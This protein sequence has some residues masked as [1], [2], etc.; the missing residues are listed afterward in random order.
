MTF[1]FWKRVACV[2]MLGWPVIAMTEA[3]STPD[4]I[5]MRYQRAAEVQRS[6]SEHWVLN[7]SVTPHWI[8][9]KNQF[10]YERQIPEGRRFTVFDV[11]RGTKSDAFDH[12]RIAYDL[13]KQLDKPI[14]PN[15]LP[16]AGL[17]LDADGALSFSAVGKSWRFDK[18]KGLTEDNDPESKYTASPDGKRGVFFKDHNLWIKD[19]K[20]GAEAR[21]TADGEEFYAY[22]VGPA[23]LS[24][25][26]P[27][28]APEV[29]WSP[30]SKYIFTAQTDDRKVLNAPLIDFA[31]KGSLPEDPLPSKG[32][33]LENRYR[34]KLINDRVAFPGDEN[35]PTFRLTI[36]DAGDGRQ[37]AVRYPPIPAVR[38]NDSPMSGNRMWWSTD[39]KT[40]Y[41]VDIE[42]G[43]KTV[44]VEAV[45][46]NT[47]AARELFSEANETF[48]ELGSDVYAPATIYPLPKSHQLIWYSER[49]GWAHL[50]LY[51]QETGRLVRALTSGN[52]V[53]HDILGVD[54]NLGQ[55]LISIEGRTKNKNPY[56]REIARVNIKTG[57][58]K[59]VS[60][61][62][63]DHQVL[64]TASL[65][66]LVAVMTGGDPRGLQ[67][68]APSG[69]YFVETVTTADK[70]SQ[71]VVRDFD[72]NRVAT[73]E[74]A[75]ASRL[76]S[77]WRW[78]QPVQLSGA[79]GRTVINA[80]VFKPFDYDPHRK[81]PL[82]DCVY[83]GPQMAYVPRGYGEPQYTEAATY[84]G[85]GFFAV[86]IDGRGTTERSRDFHTQSYRKAETTSN[87]EDHIAVIRE[88]ASADPGID[89]ARV[90]ITGF[91]GGGY[92]TASAMLRYPEFYKVGAAGSGNHDQ[93]VFWNT[94][95]E[96]Y[97]GY[98]MGDYYQEQASTT[99][100]GNLKGKLLL[101]HGLLDTGVHPS[102]LFQLE[103]AL[104]DANKDFDLLVWPRARHELPSYGIRRLWDYFIEN[105]AGESP[106]HEYYLKTDADMD[107]EKNEALSAEHR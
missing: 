11:D 53:V 42:R 49:S 74:D 79:D 65:S 4:Q 50:Y 1:P 77:W 9:G 73:V 14:D 20:S 19:F 88:L 12:M 98:P 59:I 106:P 44:H 85:L 32:T 105:L 81:Y 62:D 51:D 72:G 94:W 34:P 31:P 10:W 21:L 36:I 24:A 78:P 58:L 92:M 89:V 100:A 104:I 38:M 47:G 80:L 90:G 27:P 83:G 7:S 6:R 22:A 87:L 55:M 40:A 33:P 56:Y 54:E 64:S 13:A 63:G 96:R 46:V 15:D 3:R 35:V 29:V 23:A 5:L 17:R 25:T 26:I 8:A 101:V 18:I 30:D 97:E 39:S 16:I 82:I 37:M 52:W 102:N 66:R 75:D 41:F 71:T 28:L 95:G 76:P 86:I 45:N 57:A 61:G 2:L 103:Q 84:A 99:Y 91:S 107:R 43:E 70:P 60:A 69:R 68:A 67:G 93:R 48:V